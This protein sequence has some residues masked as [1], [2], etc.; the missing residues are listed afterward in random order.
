MASTSVGSDHKSS[1]PAGLP[2]APSTAGWGGSTGLNA[3][4]SKTRRVNA[5][6]GPSPSVSSGREYPT[7]K[8]GLN[9]WRVTR[10]GHLKSL[11]IRQLPKL[12]SERHSHSGD[13]WYCP[14]GTKCRRS[15]C[16]FEGISEAHSERRRPPHKAWPPEWPTSYNAGA[17]IAIRPW[18]WLRRT[19]GSQPQPLWQFLY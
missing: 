7:R 10:E 18:Q 19:L 14:P 15:W 17:L 11:C 4:L 8:N 1:V 5:W 3:C 16:W 13:L 12:H 9:H 2:R 6:Q